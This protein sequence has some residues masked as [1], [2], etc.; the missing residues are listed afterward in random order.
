MKGVGMGGELPQDSVVACFGLL[1]AFGLMMPNR[2]LKQAMGFL[3]QTFSIW[4]F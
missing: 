3:G 2:F 4:C 1:K